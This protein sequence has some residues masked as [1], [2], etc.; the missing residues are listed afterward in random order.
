MAALIQGIVSFWTCWC[1]GRCGSDQ[2]LLQHRMGNILQRHP[3]CL[4]CNGRQKPCL[5]QT[6]GLISYLGG[7]LPDNALACELHS[8]MET[9]STHEASPISRHRTRGAPLGLAGARGVCSIRALLRGHFHTNETQLRC[10]QTQRGGRLIRSKISW[11]PSSITAC[12]ECPLS[13]KRRKH[14]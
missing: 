13:T 7:A 10:R 14:T 9:P 11:P 4:G 12:R 8:D 5:S 1:G 6:Q 3:E 2:H